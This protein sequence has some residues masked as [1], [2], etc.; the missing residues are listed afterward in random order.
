MGSSTFNVF[1]SHASADLEFARKLSGW[2]R[3]AGHQVW[4][5]EEQLIPGSRFRAGLQ[6]GL[7]ESEHLVA[8]LS[9]IYLKRHWAQREVDLF[10]LA[11]DLSNRRILGVQ[12]EP[13][14]PEGPLDQVFLTNQRIR[15]K[16]QENFDP[17]CFWLLHCG[18]RK[19]RPGP[20]NDWR[21]KGKKLLGGSSDRK[22]SASESPRQIRGEGYKLILQ[23]AQLP[24]IP[25]PVRGLL[26]RCLSAEAQDWKPAFEELRATFRRRDADE[27]IER[28]LVHP[29]GVGMCGHASV[30]SLALL[31]QQRRQHSAW[32]LLDLGC[33][34]IT[35]WCL[36]M[37]ELYGRLD[38]EIWFSWALAGENWT[39]L[40]AA[41]LRAPHPIL[42]E[43]FKY[44]ADVAIDPKPN[45]L[46]AERGY[47]YGVMITPWNL[48]HLTWLALRVDD[49]ANAKEFAVSLC[50]TSCSGDVRSG[51]FL[52]RLSAWP[53]FERLR[54]DRRVYRHIQDAR[55][56]L[57]LENLEHLG[58][59][60][61]RVREIWHFAT[62]TMRAPG[63]T[64]DVGV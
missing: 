3:S 47:D 8:L 16:S 33:M 60:Q 38:S 29:W 55:E 11:A 24:P 27:M 61:D 5:A 46:K 12:I 14:L 52:S 28:S 21:Q 1:V 7:R 23:V 40:P 18:L 34:D 49:I 9:S 20:R 32:P 41:A 56:T 43:H 51:R 44:L 39:H 4:L 48:F 10:D 59:T 22:T 26:D 30:T 35:R 31:P 45:F 50:K 13:E 6:Q 57:G 58:N 36:S 64:P 2:L 15:W 54:V 25:E 37:L 53:L 42:Q 19:I 62:K 17:E 63:E